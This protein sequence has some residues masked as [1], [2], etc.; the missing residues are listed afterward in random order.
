MRRKTLI[1]AAIILT[2]LMIITQTQL[3]SAGNKGPVLNYKNYVI[4]YSDDGDKLAECGEYSIKMSL[5][6]ENTGD[7][8]AYDVWAEVESKSSGVEMRNCC[9]YGYPE[10]MGP[11]E[12]GWINGIEFK[13]PGNFGGPIVFELELFYEESDGNLIRE[14]MDFV[15]ESQCI[16]RFENPQKNGY[17]LNSI[18]KTGER[19]CIE[20][21]ME[22]ERFETEDHPGGRWWQYDG[23][24]SGYNK[25][26]WEVHTCD[27]YSW[28]WDNCYNKVIAIVCR[29]GKPMEYLYEKDP[30]KNGY[31]LN[32]ND[33]TGT[34][35][36]KEKNMNF[37]M[38]NIEEHPGYWWQYDGKTSGYNYDKWEV[39]TCS[40]NDWKWDNCYNKVTGILCKKNVKVSTPIW[41]IDSK[42]NDLNRVIGNHMHTS[43][44]PGSTSKECYDDGIKEQFAYLSYYCNLASIIP[45]EDKE[46]KEKYNDACQKVAQHLDIDCD[47][48]RN[49]G[50]EGSMWSQCHNKVNSI[51]W[52]SNSVIATIVTFWAIE[53]AWDQPA[54]SL[55]EALATLFSSL[56]KTINDIL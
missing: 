7:E 48:Y 30:K 5:K 26:K 14:K 1:V 47:M 36:C 27:A 2:S 28:T 54:N 45:K 31:L 40:Y 53:T 34:Q 43:L 23:K 20:N 6:L 39:H 46:S 29:I 52:R 22:F 37:V 15:V 11:G 51:R 25:D 17:L 12:K 19:F 50:V 42:L 35:Y 10:N 9:E 8:T 4:T 21:G 32:H 13:I 56:T 33:K 24:T 44:C 38:F 55:E 41:K 18:T 16:K 3:V 49:P